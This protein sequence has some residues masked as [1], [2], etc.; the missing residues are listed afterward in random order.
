MATLV[1]NCA[2]ICWLWVEML[3]VLF[4]VAFEE[5]KDSK[6]AENEIGLIDRTVSFTTLFSATK[7]E[8]T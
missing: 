8:K 1:V 4:N 3:G 5:V 6:E 7:P 2:L